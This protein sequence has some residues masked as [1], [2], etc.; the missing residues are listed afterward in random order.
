MA[1][2]I[3]RPHFFPSI[4]KA[5]SLLNMHFGEHRNTSPFW[6][7]WTVTQPNTL[8]LNHRSKAHQRYPYQKLVLKRSLPNLHHW[9]PVKT[10]LEVK[11]WSMKYPRVS[12]TFGRQWSFCKIICSWN[13]WSISDIEQVWESYDCKVLCSNS[14]RMNTSVRPVNVQKFQ[15]QMYAGGSGGHGKRIGTLIVHLLQP[16]WE[17]AG[18]VTWQWADALEFS[19]YQLTKPG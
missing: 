11:T 17:F 18:I 8:N 16:T 1:C 6:A 5:P 12:Q 4:F 7:V 10:K 13:L 15:S 19:Q 3:W 9:Q 14:T 2:R